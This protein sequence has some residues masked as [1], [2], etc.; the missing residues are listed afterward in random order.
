[1]ES[2]RFKAIFLDSLCYIKLKRV[3]NEWYARWCF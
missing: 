2:E 1:M 3:K